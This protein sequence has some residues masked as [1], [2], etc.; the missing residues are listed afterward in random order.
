MGRIITPGR[1]GAEPV[2]DYNK[3][4]LDDPDDVNCA[5]LDYFFAKQIG[6]AVT[7]AYKERQ[8]GVM[9]DSR[10]GVCVLTCPS[11]SLTKGYRLHIRN[12]T[13]HV[14]QERAKRAAG[15]IL[16]RYGISRARIVDGYAIEAMPRTGR[17]EVVSNDAKP[18]V[19]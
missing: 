5:K 7:A 13:L 4:S 18:E 14:L 8:W 10:N 2:R 1:K 12:D 17:D 15:E 19:H 6:E 9:F 16:E 11:V 3:I